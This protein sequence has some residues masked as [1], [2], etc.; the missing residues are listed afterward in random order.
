MFKKMPFGLV[1]SG[2]TFNRMMRKLLHGCSNADNYVDGHTKSWDDHLVT[3]RDFYTRVRDAG[4]TL[5]PSKCLKGFESIGFTGH[6]VWKG[7]MQMEDD[8][9]K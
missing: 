5:K 4:L 1:N 2:R 8:K 9:L 3:L 6:V 7:I